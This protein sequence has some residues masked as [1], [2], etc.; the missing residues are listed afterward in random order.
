MRFPYAGSYEA[1]NKHVKQ[2]YEK[3]SR[4]RR[5]FM[6]KVVARENYFLAHQQ[7][8]SKPRSEHSEVSALSNAARKD[9]VYL[10]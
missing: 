5:L 3:G 1:R 10:V 6:S 7:W 2:N 9:E 8:F 4:R